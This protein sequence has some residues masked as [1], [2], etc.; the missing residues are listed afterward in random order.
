[1]TV[2]NYSVFYSVSDGIVKVVRVLYS[3]SDI[4]KS[5]LDL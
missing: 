5:L 1:M 4:E 2:D 3:A